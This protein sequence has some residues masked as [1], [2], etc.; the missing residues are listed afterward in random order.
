MVKTVAPRVAPGN[1]KRRKKSRAKGDAKHLAAMSAE[2]AKQCGRSR[3][4]NA[5]AKGTIKWLDHV[6][7]RGPIARRFKDLVAFEKDSRTP[8][9]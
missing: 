2:A 3:I 4:S 5:A 9:S 8:A 1:A 6:D 7:K